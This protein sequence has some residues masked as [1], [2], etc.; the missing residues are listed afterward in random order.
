[1]SREEASEGADIGRTNFEHE[2]LLRQPVTG[3][4]AGSG[5][6]FAGLARQV[7]LVNGLGVWFCTASW[8]STCRVMLVPGQVMTRVVRELARDFGTMS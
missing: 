5:K 2:G 1:M 4:L 7:E 8:P 6:A 3:R